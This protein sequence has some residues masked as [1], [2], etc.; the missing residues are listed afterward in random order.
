[1][2]ACTLLRRTEPEIC[3]LRLSGLILTSDAH[4]APRAHRQA[5]LGSVCGRRRSSG[6]DETTFLGQLTVAATVYDS[7]EAALTPII[8]RDLSAQR[9]DQAELAQYRERFEDLLKERATEMREAATRVRQEAEERRHAEAEL[10]ASEERF[11]ALVERSSD[12][13][14]VVDEHAK[15]TYCSPSVER[16]TGYRQDEVAGMIADELIDSEDLAKIAAL[17][18]RHATQ[19]LRTDTGTLRIHTKSGSLRWFEWSASPH[20]GGGAAH[21][22][23]VNARDVTER[24]LAEHATRASERRYRTL[25][26]ASPDIIFVVDAD[27]QVQYVN[28]R[29]AERFDR[30]AVAIVGRPLAE[31]LPGA[32]RA[33]GSSGLSLVFENGQPWEGETMAALPGGDAWLQIRLVP[34]SDDDGC[35]S[36]V[37]GVAHDITARRLAENA[38]A[39]S[40]RRYRSLFEDSP[41]AMWEECRRSNNSPA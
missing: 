11:R 6:G 40:E 30:P 9:A 8:L 5:L 25:S 3:A 41:V 23:V 20:L 7:G 13:I 24:V 18:S 35:V 39:E 1:V 16:L 31:L 26:E 27:Q 36:A 29:A 4:D 15:V 21:G 12:L 22:V 17:R 28:E 10:R 38:L 14:L 19:R 33:D 37:L 34:L 32:T 2:A